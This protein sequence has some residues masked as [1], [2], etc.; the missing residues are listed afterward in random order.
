MQGEVLQ[1]RDNFLEITT[2][3]PLESLNKFIGKTSKW[4]WKEYKDHWK[5]TI[6]A[7][8]PEVERREIV[9]Y[10]TVISYRSLLL[11]KENLYGGA[12]PIRDELQLKGWLYDDSPKWGDLTVW[13]TK[14]KRREAKTVIRVWLDTEGKSVILNGQQII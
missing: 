10:T 4:P 3:Q 1:L 8:V 12:K 13:Q 2:D 7:L 6:G 14:V 11:D 9:A 5:M